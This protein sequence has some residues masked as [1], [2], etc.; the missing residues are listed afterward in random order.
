MRDSSSGG[1]SSM[2]FMP[3]MRTKAPSGRARTPYSVSPLRKLH[4]RGP[5]PMKNCVAFMPV[6]R[7][8]DEVAEL[9]HED[10]DQHA[11]HEH[12]PPDVEQSRARRSAPPRR[13]R[14]LAPRRPPTS[15]SS[16][17][18]TTEPPAMTSL[19][20]RPGRRVGSSVDGGTG[21]GGSCLVG[22]HVRARLS[23]KWIARRLASASASITSSTVSGDAPSWASRTATETSAI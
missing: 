3:M 4:S 5:N 8:V 11:D 14:R 12:Q 21:G 16:S 13:A 23:M 22:C 15:S 19:V 17:F 18:S 1:T 20:N 6:Q 2:L 7:A 10:R 9:V